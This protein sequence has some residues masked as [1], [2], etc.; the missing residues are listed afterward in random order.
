MRLFI[1]I[2]A[3]CVEYLA[4]LQEQLRQ[5][6]RGRFTRPENL[7]ITLKFLG[8]QPPSAVKG[9][10]AAIAEA[11][12][13]TLTLEIGGARIMGRS[14]ILS[15]DVLGET[16]KLTALAGRLEAALERLGV[17]R[18]ARPYRAHITLARDF[19]PHGDISGM[20]PGERRFV[21]DEVV[22]F[23]SRRETG[24]LVYAPLFSH[25]LRGR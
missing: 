9:I 25:K 16:D 6:G 22:L 7:H 2:K 19:R 13:E 24:R 10:C 8:E 14:G 18:E 1:G 4:G 20:P 21:A 12:G 5:A 3:G 15:A 11:S 23:E 17:A